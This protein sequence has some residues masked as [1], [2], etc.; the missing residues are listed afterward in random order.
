LEPQFHH[1]VDTTWAL[2]AH[3]RLASINLKYSLFHPENPLA[4]MSLADRITLYAR[5]GKALDKK[6]PEE[7]ARR[8]IQ[9]KTLEAYS[10]G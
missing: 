3:E 7:S 10:H 1:L 6:N 2:I 9:E 4:S 8:F 5:L